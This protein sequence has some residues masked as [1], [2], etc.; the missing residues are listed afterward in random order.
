MHVGAVSIF[1]GA[2]FFDDVGRF[3]LAEARRA[4]RVAAAP[5]PAVPQADHARAVRAG[6]ADLGR[7]RPLRHRVPRAAHRAAGA[8]EPRAAARAHRAHPGAAARPQ[9]AALGAVVRRGARGRQRRADPEDAPR[10]RR[11]GVRRRRRDRAAR[12]HARPHVPRAAA[13]D[14]PSRRR[15]RV[16][17]SST[18][19]T[20][21]ST[22]PAEI[23]RT[24]RHARARPRSARLERTGQL[25]RVA[26]TLVDRN[27]IAPRTSINVAVGRRRRFEGVQISLDDV[28]TIRKA[29]GGTRE[30]RRARRRRGRA[31]RGCSSRAAS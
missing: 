30:R 14:R 20:S 23:A 25:G 28:K 13:L 15:A 24:V 12:L 11:R 17:C 26:R 8:G 22:E 19:C 18:R 10:A 3:R 29:F 16:A 5:H 21:A 6:P 2:P 1:E 9:P 4:R 31:A 7:R 27:S